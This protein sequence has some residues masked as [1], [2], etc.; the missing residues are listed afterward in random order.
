M[1]ATVVKGD[2]VTDMVAIPM[3]AANRKTGRIKNVIDHCAVATT[4]IDEVG[5]VVLYCPIPSN[6]VILSV[7]VTNDDL[8]SHATPTLK[9]NWGLAYTGIGGNQAKNGH[10]LGDAIDDDVFEVDD[11]ALQAAVLVPDD[12]RTVTDAIEDVVKE[13]WDAAGLTA[14]PGGLFVV[15]M[16]VHTTA[17]ATAAAGDV[18]VRVNY[19]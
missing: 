16:T 5:D 17:A 7:L 18:V 11:T 4:S 15:R 10:A 2:M 14:D 1:T 9:V 19:I 6:A 13:A 12:K 8:D 3:V